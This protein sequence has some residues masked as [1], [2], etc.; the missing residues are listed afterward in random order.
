M[1]HY[2]KI[3]SFTGKKDNWELCEPGCLKGY[4]A[5]IWNQ[6]GAKP[7][8][9]KARPLPFD[10]KT[11]CKFMLAEVECLGYKISKDG[12]KPT[13]YKG[14]AIKEAPAQ[15]NVSEVHTFIGLIN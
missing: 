7:V 11:K 13:E 15:S 3:E 2:G 12:V 8:F 5:H 10:D 14:E 6:E 1:A 4:E 9:W